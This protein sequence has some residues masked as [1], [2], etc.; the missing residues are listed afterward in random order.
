MRVLWFFTRQGRHT[1]HTKTWCSKAFF[2]SPVCVL[3]KTGHTD[4]RTH[5]KHTQGEDTDMATKN[6]LT[7]IEC[8]N[9]APGESRY[10]LSDG[11][12]SFLGW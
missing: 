8:E 3:E 10:T 11:N 9:A 4:T 2:D 1:K 5:T 7:A 12:G 6:Q